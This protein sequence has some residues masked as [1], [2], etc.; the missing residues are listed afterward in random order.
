MLSILAFTAASIAAE[1]RHEFSID[2]GRLES[3]DPSWNV[4]GGKTSS[5]GGIRA[6]YGISPL[7]TVIGSWHYT[8]IQSNHGADYYDYS[9]EM[10]HSGGSSTGHSAI[11]GQALSE[12]SIHHLSIGT[13]FSHAVQ[14]WL[15]P[16]ATTQG[17]LRLGSFRVTDNF[18]ADEAMID[19]RSSGVG[20]GGLV[21]AGLEV[22][23]K[24]VNQA[25][26]ASAH[27]ELGY[28]LSTPLAFEVSTEDS[29]ASIGSLGLSGPTIS[30]GV[31]LR[32]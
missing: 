8:R 7:L 19:V 2:L 13:K 23:S 30:A 27:L 15:V 20:F 6:G 10:G 22:R 21:S 17:Q 32:F 4:I 18:D 24:P 12:L 9:E 26:S 28:A 31:G 11:S 3:N 25:F 5:A 16:Y 1:P 29:D 14:P